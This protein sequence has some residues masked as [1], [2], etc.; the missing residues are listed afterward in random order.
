MVSLSMRKPKGA[1]ERNLVLPGLS[2]RD[3]QEQIEEETSLIRDPLGF[4]MYIWFI[5]CVTRDDKASLKE[6]TNEKSPIVPT[7]TNS[8]NTRGGQIC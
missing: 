2:T 1:S 8:S 7:R 5:A 4:Y 3:G 6:G